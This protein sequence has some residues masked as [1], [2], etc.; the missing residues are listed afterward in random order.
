MTDESQIYQQLFDANWQ[1]V[2]DTVRSA[3]KVDGIS[4]REALRQLFTSETIDWRPG[5]LVLQTLREA[6]LAVTG[7]R[8][9]RS[10]ITA[11]C[12][13]ILD[14]FTALTGGDLGKLEHAVLTALGLDGGE[15]MP[16]EWFLPYG[17][18][19]AGLI[20]EAKSI[21]LAIVEDLVRHYYLL[22]RQ[23]LNCG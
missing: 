12:Q 23:E 1:I 10:T 13:E 11:L 17:S 14:D 9:R 5:I 21:D 19:A 2:R 4:H 7:P 16:V 15:P 6:V 3:A 20:I 8:F 22:H 18:A